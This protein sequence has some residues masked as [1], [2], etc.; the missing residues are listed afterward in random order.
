MPAAPAGR[1]VL[2][3]GGTAGSPC[4][5][6][7]TRRGFMLGSS[8]LLASLL[9]PRSAPAA[10][11]REP[12]RA[13]GTTPPT[14]RSPIACRITSTRTGAAASTSRRAR[15]STPTSCSRTRRPRSPATPVRRAATIARGR[16]WRADERVRVGRQGARRRAASRTPRAGVTGCAAAA[17]STSSSTPRSPGRCRSPGGRARRSAS[18]RPPRTGSPT[19]IISTTAGGFWR[20]PALRLNQVN[21]Y[22][23]MYVGGRRRSAG[24]S[25]SSTPSCSASC[26]VSSTARR[27][28]MAGAAISNLGPSYRFHYLPGSSENHKYNLDSAEYANIVCGFLVAYRQARDAGMAPLDSTRANVIQ[29]WVE[30][31]LAGYWTHA[32]YLNWDTG[33]GFKRWHQG[34]KLG[35]S[36]AA[37][38]GIAVA[39]ELARAKDAPMGQAPA[40]PQL[41]AL[42]PLDGA[43]PRPAAGERVR[44]AVDRRQRGL[45]G[46]RRGARA[47][48]RRPGGALRAREGWRAPSRR[49]C[50][51]TTPTSAGWPSPRPPTTRRS[52]PSIA[53][54][55]R[56]AGSS[57]RACST[58]SRTSPAASAGGRRPPSASSSATAPA[59]SPR[60]RSAL[61]RPTGDEP[62]RLLEAP[63]GTTSH[64]GS[65]PF[66]GPFQRLRVQGTTRAGGTEI[67][68]THRFEKDFIETEW[69]VGGAS[70]K[71]VEVL[72]PSWGSARISAVTRVGRAP[73]GARGGMA[74]SDIAWFHV[75]SERTGYVVAIRKG[76]SGAT[77]TTP[78][79]RPVLRPAARPDADDQGQGDDDRRAARPRPHGRRGPSGRDPATRLRDG[80]RRRGGPPRRPAAAGTV[81]RGVGVAVGVSTGAA[82]GAGDAAGRARRRR[83]RRGDALGRAGADGRERLR[84]AERLLLE[85]QQRQRALLAADRLGLQPA[86]EAVHRDALGGGRVAAVERR[87]TRLSRRS[88]SRVSARRSTRTVGRRAFALALR[89]RP[90]PRGRQRRMDGP[91]VGATGVTV[92]A[93]L[94]LGCD[95]RRLGTAACGTTAATC[96]TW[97]GVDGD[98]GDGDRPAADH[99]RAAR[100]DRD[101]LHARQPAAAEQLRDHAPRAPA[102]QPPQP[103]RRRAQ[104]ALVY[105]AVR[106]APEVPARDLA[107]PHARRGGLVERVADGIAGGLA[108][109]RGAPEVLARPGEQRA[110]G[111]DGRSKPAGDLLVREPVDRAHDQHGALA[112]RQPVDVAEQ[113]AGLGAARELVR[114]LRGDR[115][116]AVELDVARSAGSA[117]GAARPRTRCGPAAAATPRLQRHHPPRS[118]P[119]TRRK[120]SCSTS[121]GSCPDA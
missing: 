108:R 54:R 76:A 34:K 49:R 24:R 63:R 98:L 28:P 52:W 3:P 59:G 16:S 80:G 14:G 113:R 2:P 22:A 18:T 51:P 92:R 82:V 90:P 74:L 55:S 66:A 97:P 70:G 120:T 88:S 11:F 38:L 103:R 109:R 119:C 67:R 13:P 65:Y 105:A 19:C 71:T 27:R 73:P 102:R 79:R 68:T 100:A 94:R 32:G 26:G 87:I 114:Q 41:R 89:R 104:P 78:A 96:G 6:N 69:H 23:R 93:R 112:V 77:A 118:A 37:L 17:S 60:P 5:D 7:A 57:S 121:S 86:H 47:G 8:A 30:R 72:F 33:L 111:L 10:R 46:A 25:T 9:L 4:P 56:T 107:R 31:V 35:L 62:L 40:R 36:Q 1:A 20:W 21:W 29:A 61:T 91:G 15:C 44:G 53:A 39:P 12:I 81:A 95:A 64:P 116:H 117:R 42:R 101:L 58:A 99:E 84:R 115:G 45:A 83:G 110:G 50:T 43:R 48:Q 106:A 85:P 75:E